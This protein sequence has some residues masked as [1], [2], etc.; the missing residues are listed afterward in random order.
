MK[1]NLHGKYLF[2]LATLL[3]C[4]TLIL[5][6]T[7]KWGPVCYFMQNLPLAFLPLVV[8]FFFGLSVVGSI[9]YLLF[10]L[11]TDRKFALW[12]LAANLSALLIVLFV[13][14]SDTHRHFIFQNNSGSY[15]AVVKLAEAEILQ[16]DENGFAVLPDEYRH[17]SRCGGE[18]M[19]D[20]SNGVTRVFFFTFRDMF[21]DF[22]GYLYRSD[23]KTP[24]PDDFSNRPFPIRSWSWYKSLM[25]HWFFCD[26]T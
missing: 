2:F 20:N 4:I 15:D 23:D 14:L 9:L 22:A 21:D 5:G 1:S 7:L 16:P 8:W 11:R 18:I 10:N 26:N 12:L 3:V 19:I 13:P 25:P 6:T 24:Q 17:L